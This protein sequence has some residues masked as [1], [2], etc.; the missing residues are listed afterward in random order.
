MWLQLVVLGGMY[1]FVNCAH[2]KTP[3]M[4]TIE[5]KYSMMYSIHIT[6]LEV[7]SCVDDSTMTCI[8][9]VHISPTQ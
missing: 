8:Y 7:L 2:K 5:I 1:W 3:F 4:H 9:E 6:A